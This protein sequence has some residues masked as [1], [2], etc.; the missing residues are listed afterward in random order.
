MRPVR[1][2]DCVLRARDQQVSSLHEQNVALRAQLETT[3][4]RLINARANAHA[5][6]RAYQ[7]QERKIEQLRTKLQD[8]R[9]G[10]PLNAGN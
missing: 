6:A 3:E 2:F 1:E 5:D 4:R 7:L 9:G 8:V 10:Q